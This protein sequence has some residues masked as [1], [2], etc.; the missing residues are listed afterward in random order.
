[1][2]QRPNTNYFDKDIRLH[3]TTAGPLSDHYRCTFGMC[4]VRTCASCSA[5]SLSLVSQTYDLLICGTCSYAKRSLSLCLTHQQFEF[6]FHCQSAFIFGLTFTIR[7]PKNRWSF[8]SFLSFKF[9][10]RVNVGFRTKDSR[11]Y[12]GRKVKNRPSLLTLCY[13]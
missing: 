3:F 2:E 8:V 9:K 12:W 13:C 11:F 5:R 4:L 1:M 7:P 6:P 10:I